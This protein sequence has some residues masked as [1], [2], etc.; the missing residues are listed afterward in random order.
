M[1]M[2][3]KFTFKEKLK[4]LFRLH[5]KNNFECYS[6][7]RKIRVYLLPSYSR[8][9]NKYCTYGYVKVLK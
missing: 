5:D 2:I 9:L 6:C 8:I 7:G 1:K 4:I 3:D